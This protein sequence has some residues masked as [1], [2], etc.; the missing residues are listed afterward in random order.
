[1]HGP[2]VATLLADLARQQ[3]GTL[4]TF[5]FRATAPLFHTGPFTIHASHAEK[6]LTLWAE[7]PDGAQAMVAAAT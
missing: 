4:S 7:T 3:L 6:E 1:M 2:L 5:A